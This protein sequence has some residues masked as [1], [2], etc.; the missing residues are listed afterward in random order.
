VQTDSGAPGTA[1]G[2]ASV[3]IRRGDAVSEKLGKIANILKV[4]VEGYEEEVLN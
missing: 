1:L 2:S 3:L 4:D